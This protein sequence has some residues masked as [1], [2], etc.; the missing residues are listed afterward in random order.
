MNN[1]R[2]T[3]RHFLYGVVF[4]I[5][6]VPVLYVTRMLWRRRSERVE[7]EEAEWP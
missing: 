1:W 3:V 6:L 2:D 4:G 5:I 7:I